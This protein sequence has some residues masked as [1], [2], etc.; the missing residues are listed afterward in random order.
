[1]AIRTRLCNWRM[2]SRGGVVIL[3]AALALVAGGSRAEGSSGPGPAGP[4]LGYWQLDSSGSVFGH[5]Q[6][7]DFYFGDAAGS[8]PVG[9]T[10]TAMA[11]TPDVSGYWI[12]TSS[13]SVSAFG[14]AP[15]LGGVQSTSPAVGIAADGPAGYWILTADGTVN[16]FG[17]ASSAPVSTSVTTSTAAVSV[18]AT[19]DGTGQWVLRSDGFVTGMGTA[20]TWPLTGRVTNATAL[21]PTFDGAGYWVLSSDGTLSAAGDAIAY[22]FVGPRSGGWVGLA[23]TGDG[24]GLF[25]ES[26]DGANFIQGDASDLGNWGAPTGTTTAIVGFPLAHPTLT[27]LFQISP[28]GVV[29]SEAPTA[30][31]ETLTVTGSG[32][33]PEVTVYIGNDAGGT[34]VPA[35][36]VTPSAIEFTAPVMPPGVYYAGITT[37]EGSFGY[38]TDSPAGTGLTVVGPEIPGTPSSGWGVPLTSPTQ[39]SAPTVTVSAPPGPVPMATSAWPS[40]AAVPSSTPTV[41]APSARTVSKSETVKRSA[42]KSQHLPRPGAGKRVPSHHRPNGSRRHSAHHGRVSRPRR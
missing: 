25:A 26:S 6:A 28:G 8:L 3:V 5:G 19:P 2:L 40:S 27:G 32:F 34:V 33:L 37:P 31:G 29:S 20:G 36:S 17:T 21:V 14:D 16:G 35:T 24:K 38:S 39:S 23:A 15:A 12:L 1:M 42:P 22:G 7:G 41:Q 13:G 11:L 18:V 30:G 4:F 10:A 9:S